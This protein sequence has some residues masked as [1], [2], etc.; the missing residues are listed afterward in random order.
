MYWL[1]DNAGIKISIH[2]SR[3]GSDFYYKDAE[4]Y[5]CISIHASRGGS[6]R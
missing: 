6:D 3:G 2:A 4:N 5:K 1:L